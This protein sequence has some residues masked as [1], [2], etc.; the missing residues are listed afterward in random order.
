VYVIQKKSSLYR[1]NL[2]TDKRKYSTNGDGAA[3]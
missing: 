1:V 2:L 3:E